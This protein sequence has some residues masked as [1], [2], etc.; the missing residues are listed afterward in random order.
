MWLEGTEYPKPDHRAVLGVLQ[1]IQYHLDNSATVEE[2]LLADKK[3]RI[4]N[5]HS[6]PL[7]YLI[8]DATGNVATV[9][10]LNGKMVA[11]TGKDL[12]FPVLTNSVYSESVQ[13]TSPA[14]S[15]GKDLPFTDNSL[16]R[17]ATA[18]KMINKYQSAPSGV[19]T[20][21]YAFQILGSV[22]QGSFTKWSIAYDISGRKIHFQTEQFKDRKFI[23]FA[24]FDFGCDGS[25]LAYNMNQKGSGDVSENFTDASFA[26]NK[27]MLEKAVEESGSRLSISQK[28]IDE[29][30]E[31]FHFSECA[32]DGKKASNILVPNDNNWTKNI[33]PFLAI[34]AFALCLKPLIL[35]RN[36]HSF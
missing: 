18:C 20:V 23:D 29:S 8:A 5:E 2:V 13:T 9:E 3:V 19:S 21:D 10:F 30:A 16:E 27:S 1:W 12:K 24:A 34:I 33:L 14:L 35:A 31:L 4:K 17:F 32:A 36:R 15:K 25:R 26:I 22:S 7:H 11:H 28:E 6:T